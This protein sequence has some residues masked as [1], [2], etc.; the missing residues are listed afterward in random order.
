MPNKNGERTLRDI[1]PIKCEVCGLEIT[2]DQDYRMT[3]I[4][5]HMRPDDRSKCDR[6]PDS[7]YKHVSCLGKR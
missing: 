3:G 7:L 5:P 6:P 2:Q 4:V 1:F